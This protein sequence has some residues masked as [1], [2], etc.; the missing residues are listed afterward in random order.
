MTRGGESKAGSNDDGL[1][2]WNSCLPIPTDLL[3]S[4]SDLDA[5]VGVICTLD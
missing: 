5:W 3:D 2:A 1:H 4:V